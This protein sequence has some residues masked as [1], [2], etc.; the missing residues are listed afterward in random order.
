M[1]SLLRRGG[2]DRPGGQQALPPQVDDGIES[3]ARARSK[4][5]EI[6]RACEDDLVDRLEIAGAEEGDA[7]VTGDLLTV[8][9]EKRLVALEDAD[10]ERAKQLGREPGHLGPRV[11]QDAGRRAPARPGTR[12]TDFD[13]D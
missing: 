3:F 5:A 7:D 8:R 4:A 6:S 1:S 12:P 2:R 10:T 9:H 13:L 11:D